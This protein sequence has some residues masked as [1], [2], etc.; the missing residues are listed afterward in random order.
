[1][2]W[3]AD[4]LCVSGGQVH[5]KNEVIF[6]ISQTSYQGLKSFLVVFDDSVIVPKEHDTIRVFFKARNCILL[7]DG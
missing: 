1:M 2:C 3:E 6:D 4:C 7:P 5:K